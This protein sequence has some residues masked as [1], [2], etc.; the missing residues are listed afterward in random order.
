VLTDPLLGD[1]PPMIQALLEAYDWLEVEVTCGDCI[2]GRCH[3]GGQ[4]SRDSIKA[5]QEGREYHELCGCDRHA[6][7]VTARAVHVALQPLRDKI[8]AYQ[9]EKAAELAA[10]E[11]GT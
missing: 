4:A 5:V 10:K 11:A 7:S 8:K 6:A 9:A 3:W 2:T 1:Y